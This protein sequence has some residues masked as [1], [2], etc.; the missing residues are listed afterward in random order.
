MSEGGEARG[1]EVSQSYEAPRL[2]PP[3]APHPSSAGSGGGG[4]RMQASSYS[5]ARPAAPPGRAE[6]EQD[7][8]FLSKLTEKL[9]LHIREEV[10]KEMQGCV[11][12]SRAKDAVAERMDSYLQVNTLSCLHIKLYV[13]LATN[14][15]MLCSQDELQTHVCKICF[16]VMVSPDHTPKLLFPCGHTFCSACL[17]SMT[18]TS[19]KAAWRCPYCRQGIESIA[20]NQSLKE[21]IDRFARQ[22]FEV[23]FRVFYMHHCVPYLHYLSAVCYALSRHCHCH[24]TCTAGAAVH[25]QDGGSGRGVSLQRRPPRRVGRAGGVAWAARVPRGGPRAG[26]LQVPGGLPVGGDAAGHPLQRAGGRAGRG[27]RRS[28]EEAEDVVGWV[29]VA[30]VQQELCKNCA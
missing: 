5:Y 18:S 1:R 21:L 26:L 17:N 4:G 10:Q 7:D 12:G 11:S 8:Q 13:P 16:Q 24:C 9:S 22:K 20:V 2:Q 25:V 28:E 19:S 6:P 15:L 30:C 23:I 14:T 27:G 29:S 3:P